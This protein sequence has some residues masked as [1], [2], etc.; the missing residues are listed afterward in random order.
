[1][2]ETSDGKRSSGTKPA[3]S[4]S[5][6]TACRKPVSTSSPSRVRKL[7]GR[8]SRCVI[9]RSCTAATSRAISSA[10][11][12]KR[13]R[14]IGASGINGGA[15]PDRS[16]PGT[17]RRPASS[18]APGGVTLSGSMGT[19]K[20]ARRCGLTQCF[21]TAA[22]RRHAASGKRGMR[23]RRLY[24]ARLLLRTNGPPCRRPRRAA[25]A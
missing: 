7:S 24:P 6:V 19:G 18:R 12:R 23:A 4:A 22:H 17:P 9:P 14:F 11:R 3:L 15:S 5:N 25:A 20:L 8:M 16:M 21:C 13:G 10:I 2:N 1:M